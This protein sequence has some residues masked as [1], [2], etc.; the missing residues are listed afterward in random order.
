MP[1]GM[2][3]SKYITFV[4]AAILSMMAG[5]QTVHGIYQPLKV[6]LPYFQVSKLYKNI[7]K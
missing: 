1:A 5:S 3:W 4:T 6:S 7:V 2:S